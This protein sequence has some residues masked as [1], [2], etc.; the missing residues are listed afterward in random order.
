MRGEHNALKMEKKCNKKLSFS[1]QSSLSML[2]Q[3][4][5]RKCKDTYSILQN[6]YLHIY[7]DTFR[8]KILRDD[9]TQRIVLNMAEHQFIEFLK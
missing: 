8:T 6:K 4:Y 2:A 5:L 7:E 1:V 3:K 9:C